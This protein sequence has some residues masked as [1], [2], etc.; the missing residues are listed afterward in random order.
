MTL[1][2]YLTHHPEDG[3][4]EPTIQIAVRRADGKIITIGPGMRFIP[5]V[6]ML[7]IDIGTLLD[8]EVAEPDAS[9][10]KE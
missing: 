2:N 7:G 9:E 3:S 1:K 10:I 8:K 5:G 4:Y 6:F